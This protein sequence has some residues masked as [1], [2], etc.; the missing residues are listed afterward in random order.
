[1]TKECKNIWSYEMTNHNLEYKD[2]HANILPEIIHKFNAILMKVPRGLGNWQKYSD[3]HLKEKTGGNSYNILK[4]KNKK[5]ELHYQIN[6]CNQTILRTMWEM[7]RK[8]KIDDT[9]H[10]KW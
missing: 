5:G 4:N 8:K 1:M 10:T 6:V 2:N 9:N 3:I 7:G